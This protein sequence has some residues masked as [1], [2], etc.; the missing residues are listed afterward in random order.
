M[1]TYAL[2][3]DTVGSTFTLTLVQAGARV[4]GTMRFG[5]VSG[6]VTGS[7]STAGA[8]TLDPWS[9]SQVLPFGTGVYRLSALGFT[10]S[11]S[12]LTGTFH[13]N[14]TTNTSSGAYDADAALSGVSKS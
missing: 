7:A 13:I 4:S 10:V 8:V 3:T 11:G 1:T 9:F 14:L 5:A 2:C 6:T 12:S